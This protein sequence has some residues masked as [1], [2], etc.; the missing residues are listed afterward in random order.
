M[1]G[2]TAER[3]GRGGGAEREEG[4]NGRESYQEITSKLFRPSFQL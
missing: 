3:W 2:E 1:E 4:Y